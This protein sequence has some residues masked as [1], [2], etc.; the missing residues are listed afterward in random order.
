[1]NHNENFEKSLSEAL[2]REA[3]PA[4]FAEKVLARTRLRTGPE[5]APVPVS[6]PAVRMVPRARVWRPFTLALAA[7]LAAVAIIPAV[8]LEYQRR[9]E[10]RGM[11]AKQDLLTALAITGDQLRQAQAKVRRNVKFIQ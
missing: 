5:D 7:V 2:R 11:K 4:D 1:M 6:S 10:A 9:E 8:V 3:A